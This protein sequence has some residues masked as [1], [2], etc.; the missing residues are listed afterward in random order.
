MGGRVR[1]W[2]CGEEITGRIKG[3]REAELMVEAQTGRGLVN[4][5]VDKQLIEVCGR[6]LTDSL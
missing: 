1:E 5:W 4:G 3:Q 6:W 2:R